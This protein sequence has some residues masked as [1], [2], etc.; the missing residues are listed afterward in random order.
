MQIGEKKKIHTKSSSLTNRQKSARFKDENKVNKPEPK[1][2]IK[3]NCKLCNEY[4]EVMKWKKYEMI[5]KGIT[6]E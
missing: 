2:Y 3:K 4:N 5:M 1:K 6:G